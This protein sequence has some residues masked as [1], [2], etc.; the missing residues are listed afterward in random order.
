MSSPDQNL[1][2]SNEDDF[3]VYFDQIRFTLDSCPLMKVAGKIM[4][5]GHTFPE[6]SAFPDARSQTRSLILYPNKFRVNKEHKAL[7]PDSS[8]L[9]RVTGIDRNSNQLCLVG[10]GA[11]GLYDSRNCT[12]KTGGHQIRI[13][14]GEVDRSKSPNENSFSIENAVP[15]VTVTLRVEPHSEEILPAPKYSSGYYRRGNFFCTESEKNLLKYYRKHCNNLPSKIKALCVQMQNEDFEKLNPNKLEDESL[16][17]ENDLR[18]R[19]TD[20]D[21]QTW[22]EQRLHKNHPANNPGPLKPISLVKII[23]YDPSF[24]LSFGFHQIFNVDVKRR[25][26][27]IVCAFMSS[28]SELILPKVAITSIHDFDSNMTDQCWIKQDVGII[29]TELNLNA[30]ALFLIVSFD[31]DYTPD[32][33][34]EK[35]GTVKPKGNLRGDGF[36]QDNFMGWSLLDIFTPSGC[37]NSGMYFLPVFTGQPPLTNKSVR[38]MSAQ[39]WI[40]GS[41]RQAKILL[42]KNKGVIRVAFGS[43]IDPNPEKMVPDK[44]ALEAFGDE[45]CMQFERCINRPK[46]SAGPKLSGK[47]VAS[48]PKTETKLGTSSKLYQKAQKAYEATMHQYFVEQLKLTFQIDEIVE[49]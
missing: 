39:K 17:D 23:G 36:S 29:K 5:S 49:T 47:V 46:E 28:D 11:L 27:E 31:A 20:L 37:V 24:G 16:L 15:C 40:D 14:Q 34:F 45:I 35:P 8:L 18:A 19:S 3:D 48:L 32:K 44:S 2:L 33:N 4:F 30:K 26:T 22:V 10:M 42:P 43:G 41:L 7:R 1:K 12:L 9:I 25:F 38:K 21:Y 6:L 13:F